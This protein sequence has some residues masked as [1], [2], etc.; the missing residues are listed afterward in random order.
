MATALDV[1][2]RSMR[3][4]GVYAI[5]EDPSDTEAADALATLNALATSLP[6]G[7]VYAQTLD[8]I[9]LT[10]NETSVTVGP[11]GA[12]VTTRPVEVLSSSYILY[13]GMSYPLS[14]STLD[15]YNAID[16]KTNVGIPRT[17]WPL[18]GMPNITLTPWPI[19]SAAMTL[20]LWSNKQV[21]SFAA[22]T[23][24]LSLPP[25]YERAFIA[26]LAI[27]LAPEYDREPPPT[28][29]MI[30]NQA[31]KNIKRTNRK[32]PMM[33]MPYGIPTGG[34]VTGFVR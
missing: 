12:T 19:P 26:M 7:M 11:S 18:M 17:L 23:D 31:R 3:A 8:T 29:Q 25:G 10:A 4:L 1:I 20:N 28:V 14:I 34:S 22:L 30:A 27:D 24:V 32:S 33:Q 15:D 5:G 9:A 6:P 21:V 2:K 13:Q 16:V